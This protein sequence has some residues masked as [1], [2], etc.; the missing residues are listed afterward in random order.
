MSI[1]KLKEIL[2][3]IEYPVL[4]EIVDYIWCKG[5]FEIRW[6]TDNNEYDLE[7]WERKTYAVEL[8]E[9][10]HT[11]DGYL[12]ANG[13]DGCGQTITYFFDLSKEVKF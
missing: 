5:E 6:N 10:Y 11:Y 9:G 3:E 4:M 1:A 2:D 8:L 13:D 12:V 7:I